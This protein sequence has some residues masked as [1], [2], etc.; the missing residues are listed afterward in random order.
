MIQDARSLPAGTTL[1]S[2]VVIIGGG[3]AGISLALSFADRPLKV[4]LLESGGLT[5]ERKSQALYRGKN[6]GLRYEPLDLCRVR[7]FGGSTDWRGWAGWC[8]VFGE[9]DFQERDWVRLS[10]WP[11]QKRDLDPYYIRALETMTLPG[12]LESQAAE[13]ARSNR[14][15]PIGDGDCVNDP[16]ALSTAPHLNPRW[17]D[18]IKASSNVTVILHANVTQIETNETGKASTK[19]PVHDARRSDVLLEGARLCRRRR[20]DRVGAAD[21]ALE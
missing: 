3:A 21:A 9:N 11:I 15:L 8:K 14:G 13:Q 19:N 16:I 17:A 6:V 1:E 2:D 20:R 12:N 10:G 5:Y 18:T 7:I 4:V